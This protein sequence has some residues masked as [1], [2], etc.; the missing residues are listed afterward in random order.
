M[1]RSTAWV[2]TAFSISVQACARV[3]VGSAVGVFFTELPARRHADE[4]RAVGW[5]S[6]TVNPTTVTDAP[7]PVEAPREA[8]AELNGKEVHVDVAV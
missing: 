1:L 5:H 6:V 2:V 8:R 4:L 3:E 7:R